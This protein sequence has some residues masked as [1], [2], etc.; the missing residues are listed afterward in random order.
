MDT[1]KLLAVGRLALAPVRQ[2]IEV[3]VVVWATHAIPSMTTETSE[4][5]VPKPVPV[6][7]RVVPP[8]G[9]PLVVE[10]AVTLGV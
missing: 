9:V 5:S 6:M 1:S 10:S 3:A 7:V 4:G 2:V 8:V